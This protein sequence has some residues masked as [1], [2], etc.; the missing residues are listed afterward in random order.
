MPHDTIMK[1]QIRIT[2]GRLANLDF[3]RRFCVE[4]TKSEY[5]LPDELLEAAAN[6]IETTVSSPVLSK[7]LK[8]SEIEALR[9]FLVVVNR[10]ASKSSFTNESISNKELI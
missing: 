10:L 9:E 1:N 4:G 8:S 3:Q 7:N 2:L 6:T 5:V